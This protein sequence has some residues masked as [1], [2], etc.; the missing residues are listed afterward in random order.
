M[1]AGIATLDILKKEAVYAHIDGLGEKMRRGLVDIVSRSDL[2]AAITGVCSTFGIHFQK[3][4]PRNIRDVA[5]NDSEAS[6][7]YYAHMLSRSIAYVSPGL[8]HCFVAEPHTEDDVEEYLGATEEFF[9][10]Y[11]P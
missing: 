7:A 10:S 1:V 2:D 9:S 11:R 3:D 8:P 6:R 5:G 4:V